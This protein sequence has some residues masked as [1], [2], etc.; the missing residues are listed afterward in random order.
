MSEPFSVLMSIYIKEN[1][2][3]LSEALNS[4]LHQSLMPDEIVLVKDGPLTENL[5]EE[6]AIFLKKFKNVTIIPLKENVGLG[7]ALKIGVESCKY[8]IIAR[9]DTDDIA[10]N[11]R[12]VEEISCLEKNDLDIVGSNIEE[13]VE[14]SECPV[15]QRSVPESQEEIIKFSKSR[16]PFNH[17][18][19]VFRKNMVINSGNYQDMKGFEDYYLWLRMIKNGARVFNIQKNLVHVRT[20]E[21]FVERRTGLDYVKSE[22]NFQK[23]V[24]DEKLISKYDFFR[25]VILRCSARLI[26]KKILE[27]MY[28][29]FI[30]SNKLL[31]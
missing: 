12:F 19:V 4:I 29:R 6:I 3:N 14:S 24:L 5:E 21:N 1:P 9:M 8:N 18:T 22:Y 11:N 2:K 26:P 10:S 15:S 31:R 7:K 16:N 23:K 30:H 17:M 20:D 13:F 25:N 27:Q 28:I